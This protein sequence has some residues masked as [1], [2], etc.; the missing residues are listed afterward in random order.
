MRCHGSLNLWPR[1]EP[2]LPTTGF[3]CGG[4]SAGGIIIFSMP[5][6]WI[7]WTGAPWRGLPEE[8]GLLETAYMP[9]SCADSKEDIWRLFLRLLYRQ[10]WN[11]VVIDGTYVRAHSHNADA[12]HTSGVNQVIGRSCDGLPLKSMR[13]RMC[14]VVWQCLSSRQVRNPS[15]LT[16][17]HNITVLLN[18]V[19]NSKKAHQWTYYQGCKAVIYSRIMSH[20]PRDID[21]HHF[22]W[23]SFYW[24]II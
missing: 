21:K 24:N 18:K 9:G 10:L 11:A 12:Q 1:R 5:Y 13:W 14:L 3:L 16:S 2:I 19:Y 22:Q 15:N 4:K 17:Y 23:T 7:P 8:H 20:Y 6:N